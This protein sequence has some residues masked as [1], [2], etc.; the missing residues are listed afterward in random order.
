MIIIA[1]LLQSCFIQRIDR[2]LTSQINFSYYISEYNKRHLMS[3]RK[4]ITSLYQECQNHHQQIQVLIIPRR[5]S[6]RIRLLLLSNF[7]VI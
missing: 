3:I 7:G 5:I 4:L 6:T 2:E 1:I